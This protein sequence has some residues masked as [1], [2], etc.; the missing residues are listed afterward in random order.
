MYIIFGPRQYDNFVIPDLHNVYL[1]NGF[2]ILFHRVPKGIGKRKYDDVLNFF[3]HFRAAGFRGVCEAAA[4]WEQTR[5]PAQDPPVLHPASPPCSTD[6]RLSEFHP[7]SPS[8]SRHL[9]VQLLLF[10]EK[11][12]LNIE[13]DLQS[14]FGLHV[15][16]CTH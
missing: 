11:I 3:F 5:V 12:W 9:S 14:L 10:K 13:L 1:L 15:Y 8:S 6:P 7:I 16:S 4:V 2:C